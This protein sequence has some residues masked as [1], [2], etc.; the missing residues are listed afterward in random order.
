MALSG[1]RSSP[2]LELDRE[3]FAMVF[4]GFAKNLNKD[5]MNIVREGKKLLRTGR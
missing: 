5:I 4:F 1:A 2:G 3:Q